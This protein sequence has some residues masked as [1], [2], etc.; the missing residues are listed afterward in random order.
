MEDKIIFNR[1]A[2]RRRGN[3]YFREELRALHREVWRAAHGEIPPDY[4]VHHID[5]DPFNN[6]ISNLQA[7][8]RSEHP[9]GRTA[10]YLDP[11]RLTIYVERVHA[12][13][14]KTIGYTNGDI[15]RAGLQALGIDKVPNA[16]ILL[17]LAA[18][19][20]AMAE[21][22]EAEANE[23]RKRAA[24]LRAAGETP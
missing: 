5:G 17:K 21:Q 20:W 6:D 4:V 19:E 16:E 15:F 12:D 14:A 7:M 9:T 3:Y 13:I 2:Y 18:Y 23:H 8:P 10:V 1:R 24:E 11:I 22:E